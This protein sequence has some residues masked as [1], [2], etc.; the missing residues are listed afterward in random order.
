MTDFASETESYR[1][2]LRVHCY[3]MLGSFDEAED[4]VQETLLRAWRGRS[5]Y[6]GRASLRAWLYRIA[7][8]ACL[9]HLDAHPRELPT[10]DLPVTR[11][12]DLAPRPDVAVPWLQPAPDSALQPDAVV[13]ALETVELAFLAAIQHLSPRQRAALVLR[14][15][16]GWSARE[17]ASVLGTTPASVNSNVLRARAEL[18]EHLPTRRTEWASASA[19]DEE[20]AVVA[21]YVKALVEHD[22]AAFA[23]L[24]REDVRC[25][26]APGAGGHVGPEPTW[27]AGRA[28]VLEAWAPA[29][30]G[31][32]AVE[33]RIV[34]TRA[35]GLPA[36]ATYARTVGEFRA[37]GLVTLRVDGGRV[38][39]VTTFGSEVFPVFGLPA[40][41]A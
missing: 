13:V 16:L 25:S 5:T 28:A 31:E 1:H 37:F 10:L 26:H 23:E 14:D 12:S 20:R 6:A 29:L 11:D 30:R 17:T 34:E 39:E 33:F 35:N 21:K 41:P 27:Y 22:E 9:D 38:A 8:N 40:A 3:R 36:L 15:V 2:E 7:T 24:L 32:D 4:L 19:S 18:R